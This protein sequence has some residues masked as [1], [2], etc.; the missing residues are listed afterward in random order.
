MKSKVWLFGLAGLLGLGSLL[1]L[2]FV[3]FR[4]HTFH[5]TLIQSPQPAP[6]FTLISGSGQ[7]LRLSQLRGSLVLLY[8]G[9]TFC[10]DVCPATLADA[11]RARQLL[12]KQAE[13]V[14]VVMI[15]VDP[16]RDSPVRLDSYVRNFDPSFIG[17]TGESGQ[18][19]EAA[20]LYGIY[21]EKHAGS[22]ATSYLVDHTAT[23]LVIDPQGHLKLV[24]PYGV[25]ADEIA[26][27]LRYLLR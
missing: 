13:Q 9:Y 3:Q 7:P 16:E 26:D 5:G 19:A 23:L 1:W 20:A 27:D 21:Y 2:G 12:G 8:F 4:P 11:A 15:T 25:T 17:L 6:D 22:E 10:P 24:L 14:Q 18:I